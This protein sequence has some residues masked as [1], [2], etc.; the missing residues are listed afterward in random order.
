MTTLDAAAAHA[1]KPLTE[2]EVDELFDLKFRG[3]GQLGPTPALYQRFGYHSPDDFYEAL[4]LRL[5]DSDC[6]WA[7]V[8]CGHML[9]PS[10]QRLAKMLSERCR[11]LVGIDPDPNIHDNPYIHAAVQSLI[12]DYDP[13]EVFDLITLRMVAEH[14]ENPD[15]LLKTLR[16]ATRPG[17]HVVIY[18]V[19]GRS[20]IPLLTRLTPMAMR[21]VLKNLLWGTSPKD[22]FPTAYRMNTRR[23][24]AEMF[25][26]SGFD[27]V[28]FYYLDD[29]R[30]TSRFHPLLTIE[31]VFRKLFR[32]VGLA[33]P[34]NCLLGVYRCR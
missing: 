8:G 31:L 5:V 18:T 9:F 25:D 33:Y 17:S 28:L 2:R 4:L 32:K 27:E 30:T 19:N 34:E 6:S 11:R 20:P 29:C 7:D 23:E 10:N 15:K 12:D 14:V 26:A 24:L 3:D 1:L 13:D 16:E 21:H 22:T